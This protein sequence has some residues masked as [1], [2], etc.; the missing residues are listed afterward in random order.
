MLRRCRCS[1]AVPQNSALWRRK[2][3]VTGQGVQ[4]APFRRPCARSAGA[5][6]NLKCK[7]CRAARSPGKVKPARKGPNRRFG[8][9]RA[10][11]FYIPR[12]LYPFS[13]PCVGPASVKPCFQGWRTF[14]AL[15][16]AFGRKDTLLA[17]PSLS[18]V[19]LK[20]K[21]RGFGG[22]PPCGCRGKALTGG[23][24]CRLMC[25]GQRL[26]LGASCCSAARALRVSGVPAVR[27]WCNE[28]PAG[29]LVASQA[30]RSPE[31]VP[32]ASCDR[33][34][35]GPLTGCGYLLRPLAAAKRSDQGNAQRS[36]HCPSRVMQCLDQGNAQRSEHCP[37]RGQINGSRVSR[38][39]ASG[40]T[41]GQRASWWQAKRSAAPK[42][43]RRH[44]ATGWNAGRFLDGGPLVGPDADACGCEGVDQEQAG[45]VLGCMAGAV[46]SCGCGF[47]SFQRVTVN[48]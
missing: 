20:G 15:G 24:S 40:A 31:G 16:A 44:L 38:R 13:G 19:P 1:A 4:S 8:P 46:A 39:C 35:R 14:V 12:S 22:V 9:L 10:G 36:E 11:A 18:L 34:E 33:L 5:A 48:A 3:V 2:S 42:G 41:K 23:V 37:S 45:G 30:Q 25:C 43:C 32:K 6:R 21:N 29:Q 47:P 27:L 26:R 17:V 7:A 28:R